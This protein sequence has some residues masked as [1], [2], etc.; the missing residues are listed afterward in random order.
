[1]QSAEDTFRLKNQKKR[2]LEAPLPNIQEEETKDL[3]LENLYEPG[4]SNNLQ[5]P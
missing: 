4:I 3:M 2:K 1:M 5:V